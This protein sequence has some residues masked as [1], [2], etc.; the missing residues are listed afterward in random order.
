MFREFKI[1]KSDD[2]RIYGKKSVTE[3]YLVLTSAN[4]MDSFPAHNSVVFMRQ[5]GVENGNDI[6]LEVIRGE[7]TEKVHCGDEEFCYEIQATLP[8]KDKIEQPKFTG[9]V[10]VKHTKFKW[11]LFCLKVFKKVF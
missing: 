10:W 7:K 5:K 8:D 3:V 6:G 4:A 2:K 11:S 9:Q 1:A